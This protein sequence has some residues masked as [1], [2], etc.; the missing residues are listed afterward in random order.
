VYAVGTSLN[1]T[2]KPTIYST[3]DRPVLQCEQPRQIA[4]CMR[5]M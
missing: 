2:M 4:V 5:A 1:V 3:S